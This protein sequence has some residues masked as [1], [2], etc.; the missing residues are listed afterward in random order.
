MPRL[1]QVLR[2]IKLTQAKGGMEKKV[3]LPISIEVLDKMRG[4]WLT[5][6]TQ[7]AKMLWAAA[8]LCFFG[9]LR[10]GELTV[11]SEGGYIEGAHLSFQDISVDSLTNPQVLQV[12]LKA[13]KTDPFRI[14]VD[15]FVGRTNC[16]LRPVAAVLS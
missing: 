4:V 13:S 12:H 3:R 10:S 7:D 14:G 16:K 5:K 8:A 2:G 9:F 15:V 11:P 6:G 1:E